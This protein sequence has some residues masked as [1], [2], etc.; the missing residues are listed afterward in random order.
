M[1]YLPFEERVIEFQFR[2]PFYTMSVVPKLF[3]TK[4]TTNMLSVYNCTKVILY[5]EEKKSDTKVYEERV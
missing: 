2:C 5:K 1:I 4:S 3:L